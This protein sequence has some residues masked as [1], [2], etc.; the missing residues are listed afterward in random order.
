MAFKMK[1]KDLGSTA[2]EAGVPESRRSNSPVKFDFSSALDKVG[3]GLTGLGM[4]PGVGN[5]ADA[6]NTA[7]SAGRAGYA[8]Y[9][10]D[11]KAYKKHRNEAAINA[12]AMI[13]GAGLAVGASKLA[14]KGAKAAKAAKVASKADDTS[15]VV[16]SKVAKTTAKKGAKDI[17]KNVTSK[18]AAK[19]LGKEVAVQ[20]T[21]DT[22]N[23]PKKDKKNIAIKKEKAK[24]SNLA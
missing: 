15:K 2:K 11:D 21:K 14:V 3:T 9:K 17:A 13:P 7:L 12:A 5:I 22:V 20:K 4:I 16:A 18:K 8:K 1:N 23:K 19:D 6:A 24:K 10:G